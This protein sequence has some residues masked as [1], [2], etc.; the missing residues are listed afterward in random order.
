MS[1]TF[2]VQNDHY[3]ILE[4]NMALIEMYSRLSKQPE[5]RQYFPY[6]NN[7]YSRL[8]FRVNGSEIFRIENV[9]GVGASL[10]LQSMFTDIEFWSEKNS[11]HYYDKIFLTAI[12][13]RPK[14]VALFALR[15]ESLTKR[16]QA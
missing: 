11:V 6:E 5:K 2:L 16:E 9:G 1:K 13:F 12:Q 3:F 10:K 7:V 14:C 4:F 15:I 8:S